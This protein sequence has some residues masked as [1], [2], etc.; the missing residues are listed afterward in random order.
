MSLATKFTRST[1]PE[2]RNHLHHAWQW[3]F[4]VHT[5][6]PIRKTKNQGL[7]LIIAA[8]TTTA[9]PGILFGETAFISILSLALGMLI[10]ACAIP[11][12]RGTAYGAWAMVILLSIGITA[13]F[14]PKTYIGP[15]LTVAALMLLPS[16]L[17]AITIQPRYGIPVSIINIALLVAKAGQAGFHTTSLITF[18]IIGTTNL[19][20]ML[21][22]I[23]VLTVLFTRALRERVA[24]NATLEQRVADRTTDLTE[25]NAFIERRANERAR[26]V[27]AVVHDLR[28]AGVAVDSILSVAEMDIEDAQA[29]IE[30]AIRQIENTITTDLANAAQNIPDL[31]GGTRQIIGTLMEHLNSIG[32]DI[33]AAID[34]QKGLLSD[35]LDMAQLEADAIILRPT[36]TDLH[37]IA[38][39]VVRVFNPQATHKKCMITLSGNSAVTL[40]D[41][42]RIERVLH[43]IIG[44]ALKYTTAYRPDGGG[45]IQVEVQR[46]AECVVCRVRDNG[47]GIAAEDLAKLGQRFQR[48][49]RSTAGASGTGIGL[50]FCKGVLAASGGE[51]KIESDGPGHGSCATI[52][53]PVS[54]A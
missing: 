12:R 49:E 29:E 33:R 26:Q 6:D 28:H 7:L 53:L 21:I 2:L 42:Q 38:A 27:A 17:A 44:N 40:C 13:A 52:T 50:Y 11:T 22:P 37:S 3:Y 9:L 20:V 47:P 48:A 19:I 14:E 5:D 46:E 15:P 35:M 23:I 4:T 30:R 8:L 1:I 31:T 51:L 24:I 54:T 10:A 25:A 39:K 16:A 45:E 32:Q 34:S 36:I 41:H 43:N 18:G